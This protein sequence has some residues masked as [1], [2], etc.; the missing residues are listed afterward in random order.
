MKWICC[1]TKEQT[2]QQTRKGGRGLDFERVLPG[3]EG[4]NWAFIISEKNL[5]KLTDMKVWRTIR[6]LVLLELKVCSMNFTV[7]SSLPNNKN[8]NKNVIFK[9]PRRHL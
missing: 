3:E 8:E 5:Q 2:E 6:S 9:E 1:E 4:L 7:S